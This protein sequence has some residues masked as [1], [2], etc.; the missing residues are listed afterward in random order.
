ML[1]P[2]SLFFCIVNLKRRECIYILEEFCF[3][4]CFISDPT[5]VQFSFQRQGHWDFETLIF[6]EGLDDKHNQATKQGET[7][8]SQGSAI[9]T[10]PNESTQS[11]VDAR[12]WEVL[13]RHRERSSML[14]VRLQHDR[15]NLLFTAYG[16]SVDSPIAMKRK[17]W[18]YDYGNCGN[19]DYSEFWV[20]LTHER[21]LSTI[22]ER[23]A[24]TNR[25]LANVRSTETALQRTL[26]S[27]LQT[28]PK[29]LEDASVVSE[30][31]WDSLQH[32]SEPSRI[33]GM[34]IKGGAGMGGKGTPKSAAV[35]DKRLIFSG[36]YI[37]CVCG[38]G[39]NPKKSWRGQCVCEWKDLAKMTLEGVE[40]LIQWAWSIQWQ[41]THDDFNHELFD[42]FVHN[43]EHF[44]LGDDTFNSDV[45]ADAYGDVEDIYEDHSLDHAI[46]KHVIKTQ[47]VNFGKSVRPISPM[48]SPRKG[49][50]SQKTK[51]MSGA[52]R[53]SASQQ[54]TAENRKWH[55]KDLHLPN[56]AIKGD[57]LK[58][59][60][61]QTTD[62]S[63]Q[64]QPEKAAELLRTYDENLNGTL[65]VGELL[66]LLTNQ[67]KLPTAMQ[68]AKKY[69]D[70]IKR[71]H[72]QARK[73]LRVKAT[74]TVMTA[75]VQYKI[76]A[77]RASMIIQKKST[78][79]K[80]AH[81]SKVAP[82]PMTAHTEPSAETS[83]VGGGSAPTF[84]NLN[85]PETIEMEQ[86]AGTED[87]E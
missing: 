71:A 46:L 66:V 9:P 2:L 30:A 74:P 18:L 31:I 79:Q 60:L 34:G 37:P 26:F 54:N 6:P 51:L 11:N 55:S 3:V 81:G 38:R 61:Q 50:L 68:K 48:K 83:S 41:A 25:N 20:M 80:A 1:F 86:M 4:R 64:W 52:P 24:E 84:N 40:T 32:Q 13:R 56:I 35:W 53:T 72:E 59:I 78:K 42:T 82:E 77:K 49:S 7:P 43:I 23:I 87:A 14:L 63:R 75:L 85:V 39:T 73:E 5:H 29:E 15:L 76:K 67:G 12:R 65:G 45:I 27:W 47:L 28:R 33:S 8:Y 10:K 19:V 69:C 21:P 22:Q 16:I 44:M 57:G 70:N 17:L 58:E 62:N 36:A